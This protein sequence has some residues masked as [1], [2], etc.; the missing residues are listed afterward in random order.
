MRLKIKINP[1]AIIDVKMA[2]EYIRE[3]NVNAINKF[4]QEIERS[5]E[6]L[7]EVPELGMELS[8]K[9]NLKTDY[10]YL[11]INEYIV[12]YKFNSDFLFVYRILSSRRD[13]IKILFE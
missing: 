3:E 5:I 10:R 2:K 1:L 11:I 12:F 7:S 6:N 8:K 9:I 13:Y 4:T